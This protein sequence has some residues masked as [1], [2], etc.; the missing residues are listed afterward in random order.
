MFIQTVGIEIDT[1]NSKT[2]GSIY[3]TAGSYFRLRV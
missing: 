2:Y 1:V 3:T